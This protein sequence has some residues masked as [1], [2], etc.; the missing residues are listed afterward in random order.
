MEPG[1]YFKS[2]VF[3]LL[4]SVV[5]S[6]QSVSNIVVLNGLTHEN[7]SNVGENYRGTIQIQNT[8][9]QVK[10]VRIYQKDY[11]YSHTGESKHD[12]AGTLQRSN[13]SWITFNP[14]FIELAPNEITTINYEVNVPVIDSLD[15]TYWSVLMIEGIVPPDT[16]NFSSGVTIRT[17]IR[18]AIQIITNIGNTGTAN[19]QFVGLELQKENQADIIK[20]KIENMGERM[21]KPRVSIE[22]FDSAGNSAGTFKSEKRKTLPT[23]SI[24][25]K[26]VLEG[27]KPGTYNG[28]L[29]ADC[30]DD[31]I[32]GTNISFEII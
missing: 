20:V 7:V 31:N 14:E 21:L 6:F 2:L 13:A 30:E 22:L 16:A 29:V 4:F 9:E 23:T 24:S 10:N 28:V 11:W 17:S 12:P 19:M 3:F 27:I 1:I 26:I 5:F 18:Y 8:A 15:G 25:V 32:F